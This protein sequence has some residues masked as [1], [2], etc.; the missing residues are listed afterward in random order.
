MTDI[1]YLRAIAQ[2][3]NLPQLMR[4]QIS[5][6]ADEIERGRCAPARQGNTLGNTHLQEP[7]VLAYATHHDEPMLFPSSKEAA[8][9]CDDGEQPIALISMADYKALQAASAQLRGELMAKAGE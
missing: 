9:Y 3:K 2:N 1:E 5:S 7:E 6:A 8:A 4:D